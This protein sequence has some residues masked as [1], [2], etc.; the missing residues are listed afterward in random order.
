MI[1]IFLVIIF[2]VTIFLVIIFLVIMFLVII[3]LVTIFL[4]IIFLEI[5]FL[6]IIFFFDRKVLDLKLLTEIQGLSKLN[7]L[8]LSLVN[9]YLCVF[10][11]CMSFLKEFCLVELFAFKILAPHSSN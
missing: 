10:V 6:V 2:L 9:F 7:T 11:Q 1:I 8:D 4:V 3:F 5:I